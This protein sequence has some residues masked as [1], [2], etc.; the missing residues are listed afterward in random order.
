MKNLFLDK[1]YFPYGKGFGVKLFKEEDL[2]GHR[3]EYVDQLSM[4]DMQAKPKK[5]KKKMTLDKLLF[6]HS[7]RLNPEVYVTL[8]QIRQGDESLMERGA[9]SEVKY[10]TDRT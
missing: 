10:R 1:Y 9:H 4:L 7:G 5:S 3:R 8:S 2:T 6:D